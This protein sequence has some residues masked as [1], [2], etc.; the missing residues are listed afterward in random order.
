ML[1][2]ALHRIVHKTSAF[3]ESELDSHILVVSFILYENKIFFGKVK[4][5]SLVVAK[6]GKALTNLTF[7][8]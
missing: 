4:V 8:C 1:P 5:I 7:K 2:T 6:L 3:I